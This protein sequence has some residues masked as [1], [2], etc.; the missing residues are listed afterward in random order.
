[1]L[2]AGLAG[3]AQVTKHAQCTA[4]SGIGIAKHFNETLLLYC[5][6]R[7]GRGDCLDPLV[8]AMRGYSEPSSTF[9]YG[10]ISFQFQYGSCAMY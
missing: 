6:A 1:V 7:L 9:G 10:I 5:T 2:A 3:V 8:Q 4:A